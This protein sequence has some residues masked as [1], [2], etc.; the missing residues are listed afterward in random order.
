MNE[1]G[2]SWP[3]AMLTLTIIMVVFGTLI[4]FSSSLTT[5]LEEKKLAMIAAETAFQGAILHKNK[6]ELNGRR[7]V[8]R[9]F[10]E[11]TY[12]EHTICVTYARH[13]NEVEKCI[14][15]EN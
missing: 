11:W 12:T 10:Y 14:S 4:P 2:Y 15:H 5:K 6:G 3:E 1:K 7:Q 8:G 13:N 9:T